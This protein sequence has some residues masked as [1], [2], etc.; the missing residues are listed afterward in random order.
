ML[1]QPSVQS[2]RVLVEAEQRAVAVGRLAVDGGPLELPLGVRQ[3]VVAG[4]GSSGS[5][6]GSSTR[7]ARSTAAWRFSSSVPPATVTV[8]LSHGSWLPVNQR[9]CTASSGRLEPELA[10]CRARAA[11]PRPARRPGRSRPGPA[12]ARRTSGR[13]SASPRRACRRAAVGRPSLG[14]DTVAGSGSGSPRDP[15]LA[16]AVG[17]VGRDVLGARVVAGPSPGPVSTGVVVVVGEHR[18]RCRRPA[19]P[20]PPRRPASGPVPTGTAGAP[21]ASGT[22]VPSAGAALG[23][24]PHVVGGDAL[25]GALGLVEAISHRTPPGARAGDGASA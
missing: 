18:H 16:A 14:G 21:G 12:P 4:V 8:K 23:L 17:L 2:T 9:T 3:R 1:L 11:R 7:S 24:G 22:T 15:E 6:L 25:E 13:R 10:R 19:R 5:S 20:P